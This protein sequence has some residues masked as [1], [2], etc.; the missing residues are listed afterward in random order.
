MQMYMLYCELPRKT[1]REG[2]LITPASVESIRDV[3]TAR[4]EIEKRAAKPSMLG[5][6]D[7]K[8]LF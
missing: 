1:D 2:I 4:Q 6:F 8:D 3:S 7:G 5:V